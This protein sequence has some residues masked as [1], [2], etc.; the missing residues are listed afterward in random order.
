MEI[1]D[2][3]GYLLNTSARLIKRKMDYELERYDITTSQWAVLK[4]LYSKTELSQAQISD[5][6]MS[7]RATIGTVIFKLLDKGLIKKNLDPADRRSYAVCLTRKSKD[8]VKEI[9]NKVEKV[10]EAA[11]KGMTKSD[12]DRLFRSLNSIINNLSEEGL[13]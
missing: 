3:L 10:T 5:E 4:L 13:K 8:I 1:H 12:I 7:D 11:L 2:I 9:E 6:L